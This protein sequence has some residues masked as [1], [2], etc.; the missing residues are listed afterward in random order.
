MIGYLLAYNINNS[1]LSIATI[2][3]LKDSRTNLNRPNILNK[4]KA[5]Y[6]CDK[7]LVLDIEDCYEIKDI[8]RLVD[9][10]K[11]KSLLSDN[12]LVKNKITNYKN[13]I[14]FFLEKDMIYSYYLDKIKN[15][16]FHKYSDNGRLLYQC[17]FINNKKNGLYI[18]YNKNGV[19]LVECCYI[20]DIKNGY[21]KEWDRNANK[22]IECNYYKNQLNGSVKTWYSNGNLKTCGNFINDKPYGKFDQYLI[23]GTK[24]KGIEYYNDPVKYINFNSYGDMIVNSGIPVDFVNYNSVTID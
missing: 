14:Y 21:F 15:G 10:L 24:Y 7:F 22:I 6:I 12:I 9:S 11:I 1:S 13:G 8:S 17:N 19:K 20:D 23:N 3:I 18:K 2:L 5:I 4:K 16:L